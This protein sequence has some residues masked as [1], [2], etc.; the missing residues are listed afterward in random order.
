M[1][2]NNLKNYVQALVESGRESESLDQLIADLEDVE[3]KISGNPSLKIFLG[4]AS[5]SISEK[6]Q[7]LRS[8]FQ[9]YIGEKSYNFILL[10]I[11]NRNLGLLKSILAKSK[12]EKHLLENVLEIKV[13]SSVEMLKE[14]QAKI[15][16]LIEKKTGKKIILHTDINH[17]LVGGLRIEISDLILDASLRGRLE[18]LQQKISQL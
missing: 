9:D 11:R 1:K 14:E 10:L 2:K 3:K 16:E 18:R 17:E 12:K 13:E 7:A 6:K 5:I 15:S 8:I 4:E